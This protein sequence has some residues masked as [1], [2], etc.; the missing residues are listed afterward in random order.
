M[1]MYMGLEECIAGTMASVGHGSTLIAAMLEPTPTSHKKF[2]NMENHGTKKVKSHTPS[3]NVLLSSLHSDTLPLLSSLPLSSSS[4]LSL[5]PSLACFSLTFS[6]RLFSHLLPSPKEEEPR[7][8]AER[9]SLHH[10]L[11]VHKNA[12]NKVR[13]HT[14]PYILRMHHC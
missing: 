2:K 4:S 10:R 7:Y 13:Q 5:S 14:R 9:L 1:P 8:I 3:S 11:S 6:S 12:D